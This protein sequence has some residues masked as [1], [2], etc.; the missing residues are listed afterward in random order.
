MT[1]TRHVSPKVFHAIQ[2]VD[3]D[4]L[5]KCSE[6]EIRPILPCLVRMS[7]ISPLD[8]SKKCSGQKI[9]ILTIISGI[10]YVNSIVALLSIDF[11]ALESDVRKEQQLRQKSSTS[12]HDSVLISNLPNGL[13]LEYERSDMTRRLRLVLSELLFIQSQIQDLEQ[14]QEFYMKSSELFDNDIYIEEISDVICIALAELP[15]LLNV[16]MMAETLLHVHNGPSI[17][18]RV[19]ANFPDSFREVCSNLIQRGEKQEESQYSSIRLNAIAML[20][21]MNP[22]QALAVRAKCVELCRMPALAIT[23]SLD[24]GARGC[25]F[26]ESD[27]VA[28]VSGLL[29]GNDQ[30]IR[31]WFAL[32]IRTGQKR[33]GEVSST[34]L[35]LLREDLLCRLQ[36]II[37]ACSDGQLPDSCVV[38]ASAL[39]RLYCA[40]RGIAAIKFQD[41]EVNLIVQLLTSHPNPTP[42]GVRFASLG[43]CM[44]IACPSLVSQPEHEKRS[45]DWVQWLVREEAYFESTS[46]VSASFGEMLLLMAIHFHSN[47]LSA[48]C[49]LVCATLGMKIPIRHNNMTRMKQV[50]TQEIFTEQVVTSHAVKVPV[51]KNL[52]AN[53]TGFLPVHCIHQLLKSRAFAKHNVN[54][55]SWI[56]QQICASTNPLHPVLPLL[57]EVYVTSIIL[58]NPRNMEVT[59]KPLSE[60]EIRRVFQSSIFGQYFDARSST[61]NMDFD[62]TT[63]YEVVYVN[64]TSLTPQLLL[65]YY[66]LLYE[67]CRLT[68]AHSLTVTGRKIKIYS[69]EFMSELPIKY[70]LHHAQKDQISYSGL[71]GPLLKLLATHF[72]HLT[73]VED[74]LDDMSFKIDHKSTY[75]SELK[76]CDSFNSV[77]KN[78]S[79]CAKMLRLLL[80]M[81]PIDIWPFAE[82]F[83]QFARTILS[84]DVPRYVQDLYKDVWLRLNTVLPRR[85][86]VLTVKNVVGNLYGYS[87][88]DLADDPLQVMRCDERIFRCAPIYA[89]ILRV[90]RASLASSRSQ[91]HQHLQSNP[92]LDLNGQVIGDIDREDMCRALVAA[93][94]SAA[95][96]M[97]LETC[98]ETKED[99]ETPGQLFALQEVRSLVCSYL[100]QVFIVD[101]SLVKL[102]HFQG[103]PSE[104]LHVTVQGVPSMHIC[105][106][107]LLELLQQP[108]INKQIFAIQLLSHLST[109]YALPKSLNLC[110]T[111]LNLLYALLGAISA[112]QGIKLFEAIMPA[113]VHIS[114]A[115]PPLVEDIVQFLVQLSRVSR[116]QASLASYFH[117]HL[118]WDSEICEKDSKKISE[119]AEVTFNE[120]VARTD[121]KKV[122]MLSFY[123]SF[124]AATG[125]HRKNKDEEKEHRHRCKYCDYTTYFS[126]DIKSHKLLHN[127]DSCR[128]NLVY[129]ATREAEKIVAES[130]ESLCFYKCAKCGFWTTKWYKFEIHKRKHL[131]NCFLC[132][133]CYYGANSKKSMKRHFKFCKKR[134][135]TFKF[136]N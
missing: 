75:I 34:S 49:D 77:E 111:A 13:A 17:I 106:D 98:L 62:I 88:S 132:L 2:N 80:K 96:Q 15:M 50:F 81:E 128:A 110:V 51:T 30:G 16:Q 37:R 68:N 76:I 27:M 48:I 133:H 36:N 18:C 97:L 66:L 56:Y 86:W 64:E 61:F 67:D 84:K 39:L 69:A 93:Q 101:T 55:K 99:N 12:Q 74:W 5:A 46:G 28:F 24:S 82:I 14:E 4:E 117:D 90:L 123:E 124:I 91:L 119:L 131:H 47:Q 112:K 29:L 118:T 134:K 31:N 120:I 45:I 11:H 114:E 122:S 25:G 121:S 127:D 95:V 8:T 10:E 52:N 9:D 89:I 38:Q 32:F 130:E 42:A 40:L 7:L 59:N 104:L 83:T 73:L 126:S 103:Y 53:M 105:L 63:E 72:P 108:S 33:K 3:I 107:F 54:I 136:E 94:D 116:S 6:P 79:K 70:L 44:L 102:I 21:K 20:C 58:S 125:K 135:M 57:V 85:L 41:E 60:N 78:P 100:H 92:K 26:E 113:M 71:F 22:C 43:L 109:Q 19:V 1:F 35:Q 87:R 65:L 23:L 129:D 115:F